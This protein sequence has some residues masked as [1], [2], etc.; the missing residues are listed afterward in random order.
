MCTRA[1]I[2]VTTHDISN[3]LARVLTFCFR[4]F[5]RTQGASADGQ[6]GV[7]VI[8]AQLEALRGTVAPEAGSLRHVMGFDVHQELSV[9]AGRSGQVSIGAIGKVLNNGMARART[10]GRD[11]SGSPS[12][13][14]RLRMEEELET[15]AIRNI[16]KVLDEDNDGIITFD[17]LKTKLKRFGVKSSHTD[18]ISIMTQADIE[19]KRVVKVEDLSRLLAAELKQLRKMLD[20]RS[21]VSETPPKVRASLD[22]AVRQSRSLLDDAMPSFGVLKRFPAQRKVRKYNG[23][24]LA[25]VSDDEICSVCLYDRSGTMMLHKDGELLPLPQ[26]FD[27]FTDVDRPQSTRTIVELPP[28]S[29]FTAP[30]PPQKSFMS[31]FFCCFSD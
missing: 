5:G 17:M 6:V 18:I 11:D 3:T 7:D 30:P 15:A 20:M 24:R 9:R 23:E 21:S 27:Y 1:S 8:V 25:W 12:V 16:S 22:I 28:S 26:R 13:V 19:G 10:A 29:S 2:V 31:R 4:G 14:E